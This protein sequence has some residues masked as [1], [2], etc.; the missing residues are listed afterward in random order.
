[1]ETSLNAP[2]SKATGE[3]YGGRAKHYQDWAEAE[4][5]L[6]M[7]STGWTEWKQN[8]ACESL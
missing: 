3:G 2:R 6:G 8:D 4:R 1:M 7:R 5:L